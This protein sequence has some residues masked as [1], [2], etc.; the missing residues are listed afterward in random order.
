VLVDGTVTDTRA[1]PAVNVDLNYI[2]SA[3]IKIFT[4]EDN[5]D[6]TGAYS[7]VVPPGLYTVEYTPPSGVRLAPV[8]LMQ[9]AITQRTTIPTVQLPDGVFVTGKT[10]TFNGA[11]L[12]DIDLDF[13][14]GG[15]TTKTFTQRDNSDATGRFS[16]VVVPG[17]YDIRFQPSSTTTW[18][19][20]R[21]RG[22]S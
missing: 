15:G 20:K 14:P 13:F 7:A 6:A 2:N 16:V 18:A 3:G 11:P 21:L 4:W 5:S 1:A 17:T 22:M 12:Q 19:A 8:Q 10:I 9:I